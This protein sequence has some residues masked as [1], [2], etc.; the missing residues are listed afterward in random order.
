MPAPK[1][2]SKKADG[3]GKNKSSKAEE[4]KLKRLECITNL[5]REY[6]ESCKRLGVEPLKSVQTAIGDAQQSEL[7]LNKIVLS[8]QQLLSRELVAITQAFTAYNQVTTF[9]LWRIPL[10][11]DSLSTI[12][13]FIT[14]PGCTVS[15]L[16][17]MGC[18]LGSDSA[19]CLNRLAAEAKDLKFVNLDYNVNL[20]GRAVA[21]FFAGL[22]Q[23]RDNYDPDATTTNQATKCISLKWADIGAECGEA[24]S[25]ALGV[26][27]SLLELDLTGNPLS[28]SVFA[29]MSRALSSNSS[30]KSLS[31][32][33]TSIPPPYQKY[34][35]STYQPNNGI[36]P[37]LPNGEKKEIN[38]LKLL[39]GSLATNTTLATLDLRGN[40]IGS[41][42][43]ETVLQF[44]VDRKRNPV[45]PTMAVKVTEHMSSEVF[46]GIMEYG[47]MLSASKKKGGGKKGKKK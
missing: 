9:C 4:E 15:T 44:L 45:M 33:S 20:G 2:G 13:K 31:L 34:N 42:G 22:V 21:S 43:G 38:H 29:H 25:L 26:G 36:L 3:G 39:L 27:S 30:L 40:D 32:A 19:Q 11:V 7:S 37:Q 8:R 14:T 1:K 18:D 12:T 24:L 47:G 5:K 41:E 17:L 28:H 6:S 23:A 46:K 10:T 35:A 16:H